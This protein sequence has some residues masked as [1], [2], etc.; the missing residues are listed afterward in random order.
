M[1]PVRKD[2]SGV[3]ELEITTSLEMKHLDTVFATVIGVNKAGLST[4]LFN[5]DGMTIDV[6]LPLPGNASAEFAGD[7]KV[8]DV[9][10]ISGTRV[11]NFLGVSWQGFSDPDSGILDYGES[12]GRNAFPCL[13][14]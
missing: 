11:Q 4:T 2:R 1:T 3:F 5:A 13:V 8:P 10:G 12:F 6:T 7:S 14:P 9:L